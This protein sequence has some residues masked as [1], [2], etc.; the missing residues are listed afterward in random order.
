MLLRGRPDC[1][2]QRRQEGLELLVTA[3]AVVEA[4][5]VRARLQQ[6]RYVPRQLRVSA[7]R[8]EQV[9]RVEEWSYTVRLQ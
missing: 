1:G 5:A 2:E 6:R 3:Q 4:T 7:R 9:P 8:V